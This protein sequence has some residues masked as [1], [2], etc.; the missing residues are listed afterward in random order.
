MMKEKKTSLTNNENEFDITAP[1]SIVEEIKCQ[2]SLFASTRKQ[3]DS[4]FAGTAI[5][6]VLA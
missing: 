1:P 4:L 5:N 2:D 3:Y 6:S